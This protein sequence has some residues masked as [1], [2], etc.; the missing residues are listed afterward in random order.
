MEDVTRTYQSVFVL[1]GNCS[2]RIGCG[3]ELCMGRAAGRP[4][5]AQSDRA[6]KISNKKRAGPGRAGA[7][8]YRA[9]WVWPGC[10]ESFVTRSICECDQPLSR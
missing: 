8:C 4:G 10:R 5:P 1:Q 9:G 6:V 7:S 2:G 3:V